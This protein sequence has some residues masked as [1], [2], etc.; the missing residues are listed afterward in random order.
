MTCEYSSTAANR[1][2]STEPNAAIRPRSLRARST[3]IT[4]SA[5]SLES[6]ASSRRIRASA[7]ASPV[8]RRVP[9]MGRASAR[10]SRTSTSSSGEPHTSCQSPKSAYPI[11]GDGL[12]ARSRRYTASG[13][14][15]SGNRS[16]TLRFTW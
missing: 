4:C 2:T 3:S 7:A 14:S 6:V 5:A 16:A 9:A 12:M 10:P 8:L 13:C 1:A 11:H 15:A